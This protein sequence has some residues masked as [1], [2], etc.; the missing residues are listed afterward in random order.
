LIGDALWQSA[1][2]RNPIQYKS[3]KIEEKSLTG[4]M[5]LSEMKE[6]KVQWLTADDEIL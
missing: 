6:R 2:K 1:N 4:N 5:N 3:V